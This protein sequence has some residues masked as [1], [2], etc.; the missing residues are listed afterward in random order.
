MATRVISSVFDWIQARKDVFL[1]IAA[2]ISPFAAVAVS[3]RTSRWQTESAER[4]AQR[5]MD[6]SRDTS[7]EQ[8]RATGENV[9]SQIHATI[10]VAYK[11][12]LIDQLRD[13]LA[14][15]ISFAMHLHFAWQESGNEQQVKADLKKN[16]AILFT[17][18]PFLIEQ[19]SIKEHMAVQDSYSAVL[20]FANAQPRGESWSSETYNKFNGLVRQLKH[21]AQELVRAEEKSLGQ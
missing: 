8:I 9:K 7:K 2:L 5:Q 17:T 14:S 3:L 4:I 21:S 19:S 10:R 11:Q 1:V 6:V 15:V 20:E 12:R 16:T 13:H 18:I